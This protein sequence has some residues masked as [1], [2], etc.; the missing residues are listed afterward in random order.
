[1]PSQTYILICYPVFHLDCM[2]ASKLC[3]KR[4]LGE[5]VACLAV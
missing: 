1:M 5:Y 3:S 2:V 4:L